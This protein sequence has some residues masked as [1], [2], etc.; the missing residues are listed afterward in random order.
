MADVF[1]GVG[2]N[3]EPARH[4]QMGLDAM[5]KRFGP[6]RISTIW[7]SRAVGFHGND[8]YNLVV[9]FTTDLEI[10][11]LDAELDAIEAACGRDRSAPRFAP[12]TLDL[13]LLL[14]DDVVLD[15]PG[16]T[17]PRGEILEYAFVLRPLAELAGERRHPLTGLTFA[18]H[19]RRFE[20]DEPP[21]V[22]VDG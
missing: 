3:V 11:A 4:V 12:R 20:T 7:R 1:I 13:D 16:L 21:L 5:G 10:H 22:A 15:E 19:W 2:S 14:Y 9:A 8:F 17:I 6:L 18:E